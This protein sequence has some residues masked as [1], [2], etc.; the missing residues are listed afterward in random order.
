[1]LFLWK[2]MYLMTMPKLKAIHLCSM[3]I[4]KKSRQ[5]VEW[6]VRGERWRRQISSWLLHL[7]SPLAPAPTPLNSQFTTSHYKVKV[8]AFT[9]RISAHIT[10]VELRSLSPIGRRLPALQMPAVETCIS[11]HLQCWESD[12]MRAFDF[13]PVLLTSAVQITIKL[14]K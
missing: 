10:H 12:L 6:P 14:W 7:H 8:I 4:K 1:M 3:H 11:R 9:G 13:E 2:A 5:Q